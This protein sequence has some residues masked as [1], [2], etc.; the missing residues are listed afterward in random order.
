[1]D[2]IKAKH[3][4]EQI[5]S[6]L[7][8]YKEISRVTG[9]NFNIF[10]ILKV[11]SNEIKT[12]SA[13]LGELLNPNGSHGL[14]DIPLKLFIQQCLPDWLSIDEVPGNIELLGNSDVKKVSFDTQSA[15]VDIEKYIG[16]INEDATEGGRIDILICDKNGKKILI[17][18]KIYAPEQKNQ[19]IRYGKAHPEA[20]IFYL[21][22]KGEESNT[23]GDLIKDVEFFEISY[24]E[25]VLQWLQ[26][27]LKEAVKFPMLREV[28]NQ[29]IN[30]IKILTDQTMNSKLKEE[31]SALI[32]NNFLE[33]AEIAKNYDD[34]HKQVAE[35]YV[36]NLAR[37]IVKNLNQQE[38]HWIYE[39][40][41]LF[42]VKEPY[43]LF[44]KKEWKHIFIYMR[45]KNKTLFYGITITKSIKA[46]N[47]KILKLKKN[48]GLSR[49]SSSHLSV[50]WDNSFPVNFVSPTVI[51]ELLNEP[52]FKLKDAK[53]F[54]LNF[55]T[56]TQGLTNDL[57]KLF[58]ETKE[59]QK[60]D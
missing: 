43:F 27:C 26:Q 10:S 37:E 9:E 3:F 60:K 30:L 20:T 14:E 25:D 36:D 51:Q 53:N 39:K 47:E 41:K 49:Y 15:R 18:N 42:N 23:S 38:E 57:I 1:M 5:R 29:Y 54:M 56:E 24:E 8:K 44:Y 32:K 55:I 59:G 22:L 40:K 31:L 21:T 12:H 28:I 7:D 48:A 34:V 4:L 11:E 19:L 16:K 6:L 46:N 33:S 58:E 50:L 52:D 2:K 17:E 13:L 45:F 35:D